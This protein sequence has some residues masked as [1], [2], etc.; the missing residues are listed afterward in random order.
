MI[1][2]SLNR[3]AIGRWCLR[4]QRVSGGRAGHPYYVCTLEGIYYGLWLVHTPCGYQHTFTTHVGYLMLRLP[5]G[6][7]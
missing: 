1:I 6:L 2:Q 4:V 3:F 7:D 5:P